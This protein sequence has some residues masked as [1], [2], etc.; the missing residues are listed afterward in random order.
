MRRLLWVL[1]DGISNMVSVF[2]L[3]DEDITHT[4]GAVSATITLHMKRYIRLSYSQ[5][6]CQRT[7][8]LFCLMRSI[9]PLWYSKTLLFHDNNF[10]R[11]YHPMGLTIMPVPDS[12]QACEKPY[13]PGE[14]RFRPTIP[15]ADV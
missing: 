4:N 7:L 10:N 13:D 6:L 12:F 3:Y 11:T 2:S 1:L 14:A 9:P 8:T 15:V 5:Q